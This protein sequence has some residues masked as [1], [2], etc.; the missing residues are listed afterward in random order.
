MSKILYQDKKQNEAMRRARRFLHDL[1]AFSFLDGFNEAM[2]EDRLCVGILLAL[3]TRSEGPLLGVTVPDSE[4]LSNPKTCLWTPLG[5]CLSRLSTDE[6]GKEKE[7]VESTRA[8]VLDNGILG[9]ILL[10]L[11]YTQSLSP[12]DT[13]FFSR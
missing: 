8:Q 4:E 13:Q 2:I 11:G 5:V 7:V 10:S 6:N 1:Q 9:R 3:L 12:G